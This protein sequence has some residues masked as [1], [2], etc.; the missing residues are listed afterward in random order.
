[1][2]IYERLKLMETALH[3]YIADCELEKLDYNN[4]TYEAAKKA[5]AP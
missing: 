2:N 5:L 4:D 3:L 1:M